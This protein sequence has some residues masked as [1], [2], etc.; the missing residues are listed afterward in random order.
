MH[1][2]EKK[3]FAFLEETYV[4]LTSLL[5]ALFMSGMLTAEFAILFQFQ[6]FGGGFFI[7][8]GGVEVI[9]R[10][11]GFAISSTNKLNDIAH[12]GIP[13]SNRVKELLNQ[14]FTI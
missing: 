13:L 6:F 2:G 12:K 3:E 14:K 9:P 8:R 11:R 1:P 4:P 7:F 5:F 10:T